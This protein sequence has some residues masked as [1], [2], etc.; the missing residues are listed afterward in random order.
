MPDS[1]YLTN[2]NH[3]GDAHT[4][5]AQVYLDLPDLV[6]YAFL[7]FHHVPTPD[8][9]EDRRDEIAVLL[10]AGDCHR[11]KT[12]DPDKASLRTWLTNVV[13]NYV[14][15][16]LKH[17]R[18]WDS[19]EETLPEYL[20][21]QPRQELNAITQEHLTAVIRE[22]AQLSAWQQQLFALL[23]EELPAPEIAK[24]LKIKVA[25]VHRMK[26]ALFQK[27]RAGIEKKWG[28][29]NRVPE[30]ASRKMG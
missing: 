6:R 13:R 9:I 7:H 24:R 28:G 29:A 5:M 30:W 25:S 1:K 11:L 10:L 22:V 27:I 3:K 26:H 23:W 20:L 12:F 14:G 18:I 8:E 16:H 15:D 17:K 21:E 4:L 19:L 2:G